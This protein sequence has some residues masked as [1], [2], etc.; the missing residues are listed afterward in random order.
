MRIDP[1]FPTPLIAAD[2]PEAGELCAQLK[3]RIL[4][5]ERESQGVQHSNVGGWQSGA[6]FFDWGGPESEVLRAAVTEVANHYTGV[7]E[8]P[9]ITRTA[10]S[11][12]VA[13]WANVNRSGHAND[14]HYHPGSFW[15]A[16]FYVDDGGIPADGSK[17]GAIEFLDPR[18]AMP[19]MYAPKVKIAIAYCASAGLGERYYPKSGLLLMF[20]SWLG[21]R[22]TAYAGQ[23][24]RISI[25]MN[26]A[27]EQQSPTHA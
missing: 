22:V 21:H 15:S 25:A 7:F 12:N 2:L 20:P 23:G 1:L 26:F 11:W 14:L 6:D 24:E 17:G 18:G 8:G 3:A 4:A 16:V 10:L 9:E 5:R 13:G 27:V 19:L